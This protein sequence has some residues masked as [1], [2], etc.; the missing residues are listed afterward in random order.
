MSNYVKATNFT[1]KDSLPTGNAGKIVKGAEIDTELTAVASAISSKA[2]LNSP[3]L[4][5]SPTA[6]T[7]SSADES[8]KLATT[9]YVASK[10]AAV[11]SGVTSVAAGT[12]ISVSGTGAGPYTGA[13]T[14]TNTGALLS[15][16]QTFTGAKTFTG[17]ITSTTYNFDSNS[18]V[19]LN[20][21]K[22]RIDIEGTPIARVFLTGSSHR[23]GL[24]NTDDRGLAYDSSANAIGVGYAGQNFCQFYGTSYAEFNLSDVRKPGGGSFNSSSD[25]RLKTDIV[26]YTKGINAV[27]SLRPVSYKYIDKKTGIPINKTYVGIIAQEVEQTPFSNIVG[28]DSDSYK[29]VDSSEILFALVNAVKELTAELEIFKNKVLALEASQT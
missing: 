26:D 3:S 20:S 22:V 1:A 10:I 4:T 27:K 7:Q 18:S 8:T 13:V 6:P 5:G 14:V 15:T 12:G 21:S 25:A 29:T 17:G 2:D 16:T 9:A 23:L 28:T 11:S 19:Y 24:G